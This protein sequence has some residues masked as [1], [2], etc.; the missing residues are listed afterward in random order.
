[1]D[2][3]IIT[4]LLGS[5]EFWFRAV[6]VA[7]IVGVGSKFIANG[8]EN[9]IAHIS[10]EQRKRNEEKKSIFD[11]EVKDLIN[12]PTKVNDLKIDATYSLLSNVIRLLFYLILMNF[13]SIFPLGI[14]LANSAFNL[15]ISVFAVSTTLSAIRDNNHTRSLLKEYNRIT[16]N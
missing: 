10:K 14:G 6:I 3:S 15:I 4:N 13:V 12:N 7:T 9:L 2:I 1:M 16:R 11:S 5:Q 8:L